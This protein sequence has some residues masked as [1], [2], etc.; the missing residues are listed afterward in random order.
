MVGIM[1]TASGAAGFVGAVAFGYIVSLTGGYTMPFVPMAFL[2]FVGAM[3]WLYID[4][5]KQIQSPLR[6]DPDVGVALA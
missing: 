1:N 5:R 6:I 2:L 3:L 4:P